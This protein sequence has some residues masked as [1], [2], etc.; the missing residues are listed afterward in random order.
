MEL[1]PIPTRTKDRKLKKH[2]AYQLLYI[3]SIPPDDGLQICPKYVEV[4]W[5]NKL[6]INSASSWCSLHGFIEVHGQQ[7]IKK[8]THTKVH[9]YNSTCV[10]ANGYFVFLGRVTNPSAN[11]TG[12]TILKEWTTPDSRNMSSTTNLEEEETVDAPGNDGNAS[13][14]EQVKRPNPWRMM[15]ML[16]L[17]ISIHAPTHSHCVLHATLPASRPHFAAIP[18]TA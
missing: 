11:K 10:F 5:R 8:H 6:R 18:R 3:Y 7:N 16:I 9:R 2:N 14:P 13:M 1:S 15:M 4:G 17:R 12:S